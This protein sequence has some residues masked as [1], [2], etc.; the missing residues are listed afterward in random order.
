MKIIVIGGVAG[1]ASAAARAR[2]LDEKADITIYERG[3]YISF[4][5]CGLPYH[6]GKV[7][8]ERDA[9]LLLTPESFRSRVGVNVKILHEVI[10]ID[11]AKKIVKVK[12]VKSGKIFEDSYDKL[13]LSPGSS[14]L[15]PPIPGSDDP[16]VLVLWTMNDMDRINALVDSG[17][18]RAIVIG[19]GF[20]GVEVAENLAHRKI[21]TCLVEMLPHIMPQ[22]DQEMTTPL[23]DEME[24]NGVKLFLENGVSKIERSRSM[25]DRHHRKGFVV[26]LQDSTRIEADMVIMAIGVRPNNELAKSADLEVGKT[27]GIIV[28]K[29]MQ[30]SDPDIYAVGDAVE[31][32]NLVTNTPARIPL[33]G[34]ANRQ[35]RMA[36]NNIFGANEEYKGSL[37]TAICKV[38]DI[39]AASTGMS[40]RMLKTNKIKYKKLYINPASHASYY[41]GAEV[42]N[43]KVL[44][45]DKG[46][47]LGAQIVGRDGI[48]KRIDVLATAIRM[49]ITIQQ[50]EELELAYAPPFGSAKDPV[51]FVGFVGNNMLKGDTKVVYPDTIP[52]GNLLLDV[53]SEDEHICG[54]VKNS[55]NIPL[56]ELR[57]RLKELP[58]DKPITVMCRTGVRSYN[59]ERILRAEGFNVTNLA[60]GYMAWL[61]FHPEKGSVLTE[62]SCWSS[63]AMI[64]NELPGMTTTC[65]DKNSSDPQS[66]DVNVEL[67]ACGLQCPG[68]IVAVKNKIA[69]M[70]DGEVLKVSVSDKGFTKDI[71]SWCSS[72]GNTLLSVEQTEKAIVAFIKKGLEGGSSAVAS[73]TTS[74]PAVIKKTTIVLFSN[75]LDKSMAAFILATGF[76]SLG[77]EVTIF[78]TFWGLNVLRKSNPPSVKKDFLSKMFG[79]MMPRGAKKLALSK[80]HMMGMGTAMMKHVMNSKNVDSLPELIKQAQSMDVNFVAC[81][82]ALDVMGIQKEELIDGVESAGVA[83]FAAIAET[84]G[85]TLFI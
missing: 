66:F 75:D 68:P 70:K 18:K 51:N 3:E 36:A 46:L 73:T 41:P 79:M 26:E 30:S 52:E 80:M 53:R 57:G 4:A 39:G 47:I 65:T 85:T 8:Q 2:R 56:E 10:K 13:V 59:A 72:T 1:G 40:E 9:L 16:D 67:N 54:A 29:K 27:G 55:K 50:L 63:P 76:A 60:G 49:G 23:H 19:G 32:T 11:K 82:M 20:I 38:F 35:G 45:N 64:E 69:E 17:V 28:N 71:P 22:M 5:N 37:G 62:D 14:P 58:K 24:Q 7:I 77:H 74:A 48:D 31:I 12:D 83:N 78:F 21:K 33:A 44:F 81:E 84:S 42:M 61:L 34:P 43:L 6:V 15:R 25:D